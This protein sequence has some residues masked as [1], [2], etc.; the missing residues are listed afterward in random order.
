MTYKIG[1]SIANI[2]IAVSDLQKECAYFAVDVDSVVKLAK[3][4]QLNALTLLTE[5][6]ERNDQ[7]IGRT[8][9]RPDHG[10]VAMRPTCG[11]C[12][13]FNDLAGDGE[14]SFEGECRRRSPELVLDDDVYACAWPPIDRSQWCG[15]YVMELY[16]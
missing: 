5:H 2:Q 11:T 9:R 8:D 1:E 3:S 4:I 16:Q 7:T 12:R 15:E 10:G 6:E 14:G 13:Y